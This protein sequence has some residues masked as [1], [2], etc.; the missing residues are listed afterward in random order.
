MGKKKVKED[1]YNCDYCGA[2]IYLKPCYLKDNQRHYCSQECKNKGFTLY[3]S[4]KNHH[5]YSQQTLE[6]DWCGIEISKPLNTLKRN[7]NNFCSV[8]C[9]DE[10]F[11][12][13]TSQS[14]ET[15]ERS[16][17]VTLNNLKNGIIKT[18][19]SIQIKINDLLSNNNINFVNEYTIG[20]HYSVDNY[21]NDYNLIIENQGDYWHT[22]P[23]KYSN[24]GY[25]VQLRGIHTDKSKNTYI[26]KYYNINVLYLWETD[27]NDNIKL[28]EQLILEYIKNKGI[29]KNYES[30]NYTLVNDILILNDNIIKP[31]RE[32]SKEDIQSI[33][34]LSVKQKPEYHITFDC[35]YCGKEKTQLKNRY[36]RKKHHFCSR[37]CSAK[38][39]VLF[40]ESK[41][42]KYNCDYCGKDCEMYKS[43]YDVNETHFCNPQCRG[44]YVKK[45]EIMACDNCGVEIEVSGKK[46]KLYKLHFCGNDCMKEYRSKN[47]K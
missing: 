20:K 47:K 7:K 44:L 29:L 34:D 40:Q 37:E 17:K 28:C 25:D 3:H 26:K 2:G 36:D 32:Y 27:I 16:R 8:K 22:N 45:V 39:N 42:I 10:Y 13:V 15:R 35:E 23:N 46:L 38:G 30:F 9:K 33:T 21:L 6:C 1:N 31:Y 11:A 14:D 4:G 24:V 5:G 12:K 19:T 18:D 43:Q 41:I